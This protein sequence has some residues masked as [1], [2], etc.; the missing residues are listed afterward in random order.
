MIIS[1]SN[2]L[3]ALLFAYA[4]FSKIMD[5]NVFRNQLSAIVF[6]KRA[7]PFI[8][9]TLPAFE[10]LTAFLISF[11]NT[12]I[13]GWWLA[14]IL[15][16]TFTIYVAVIILF[17]KHL[18]CSCGGVIAAM[19]WKQHLLFNIFFM[20]V[21]WTALYHSIKNQFKTISTNIRE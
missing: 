10:I 7:A 12:Q 5:F 14:A 16:T 6:L 15:M 18:P 9:S 11:R 21:T 17:K 20:L 4:G 1:A 2:F 19:T 3:V 8:A 13:P